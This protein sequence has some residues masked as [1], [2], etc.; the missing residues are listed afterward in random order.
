MRP[1]FLTA[2]LT[3]QTLRRSLKF[4][5][6]LPLMVATVVGLN[7]C[8]SSEPQATDNTTSSY[9]EEVVERPE[10]LESVA[11]APEIYAGDLVT[12][13]GE[14]TDIY[15]SQAFVIREEEYFAADAGLLIVLNDDSIPTPN[16]G[17]YVEVSGEVQQLVVTDLNKDY[18]IAFDNTVIEEI[19][20]TFSEAPF[21]L[22]TEIS[23]RQTEDPMSDSAS[24]SSNAQPEEQAGDEQ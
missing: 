23:Y 4:G 5:V 11:D 21:L 24:E 15:D 14:V 13:V 1:Q 22:A 17:E 19:E 3:R 7:A 6:G 8:S 9:S 2:T 20:A 16:P 12:V 18:A 10:T